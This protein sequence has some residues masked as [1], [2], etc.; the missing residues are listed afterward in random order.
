MYKFAIMLS[1]FKDVPVI[2]VLFCMAV[3]VTSDQFTIKTIR[4]EF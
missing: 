2:V 1:C 3:N 4:C